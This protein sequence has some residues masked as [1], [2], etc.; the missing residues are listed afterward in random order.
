MAMS[1]G[2]SCKE[3]GSDEA[4]DNAEDTEV[5]SYCATDGK[6]QPASYFCYNCG[7]FG[8]YICD[9][10]LTHH[11]RTVK[12]HKVKLMSNQPMSRGQTLETELEKE[13]KKVE[14]LRHKLD[15]RMKTIQDLEKDLKVRDERNNDLD[16]ESKDL[17]KS[18]GQEKK[19]R[20]AVENELKSATDMVQR[21]EKHVND[22]FVKCQEHQKRIAELEA[23]NKKLEAAY[24]NLDKHKY[25]IEQQANK[26]MEHMQN[27][28]K[29]EKR[30]SDD[31]Y[32]KL[33]AERDNLRDRF[34]KLAGKKYPEQ[35]ADILD[36]SDPYR[37]MKLSERFGQLYDDEW[38][39]AFEDLTDKKLGLPLKTAIHILLDLLRECYTF[40]NNL[41]TTQMDS[42]QSAFLHPA[43]NRANFDQK[44][45]VGGLADKTK[46]TSQDQQSLIELRKRVGVSPTVI[47]EVKQALLVDLQTWDKRQKK[48]F[49]KKHIEACT[50]Y[51]QKCA[52]ISWLMALHDPPLWMKM[53]V[54]PGEKFD[55]NIFTVYSQSGQTI[56]FLVFPPLYNG[57]DGGLLSKGVA[58]P[59]RVLGKK[60]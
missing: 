12:S 20:T 1:L 59:L 38:T 32:K 33:L 42:L 37:A 7:V 22:D 15:D 19:T 56:D 54:K 3:S 34:S 24:K 29:E 46:I 6:L 36:L 40:C 52:E 35:I 5:C 43:Q 26:N 60:K 28:L 57:I 18:L 10:C 50:P 58:E 17:A 55:T 4:W 44:K 21:L 11:N 25:H 16:D 39:N 13:Q 30:K 47:E 2:H 48:E 31:Q 45:Y 49:D 8:R 9:R 27:V 51:I 53:D 14:Q 23:A 41:M